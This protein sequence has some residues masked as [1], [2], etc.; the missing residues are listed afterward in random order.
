MWAWRGGVTIQDPGS[1]IQDYLP[2]HSSNDK[3]SEWLHDGDA[4]GAHFLTSGHPYIHTH[5]HSHGQLAML[6][7]LPPEAAVRLPRPLRHH[8]EKQMEKPRRKTHF[9]RLSAVCLK[10]P[11]HPVCWGL[12]W[13]ECKGRRTKDGLPIVSL[14]GIHPWTVQLVQPVRTCYPFG[15][16][17]LA[18]FSPALLVFVLRPHP[19]FG[20]RRDVSVLMDSTCLP[21]SHRTQE[22]RCPEVQRPESWPTSFGCIVCL[23]ASSR[24]V[25]QPVWGHFYCSRTGLG[26]ICIFIW[27]RGVFIFRLCSWFGMHSEKVGTK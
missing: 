2:G 27:V 13:M 25:C 9:E 23:R 15:S 16:R 11:S 5:T 18:A 6:Q 22:F 1:R 8:G 26:V 19:S 24:R 17:F 12:V 14:I 7:L 3:L 21:W 10:L 20:A 4:K